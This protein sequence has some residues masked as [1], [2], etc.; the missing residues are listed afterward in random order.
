MA[1]LP[2]A[3]NALV[4][5]TQGVSFR[6]I[7]STNRLSPSAGSV[8]T[9][10]PSAST[11]IGVDYQTTTTNFT[12][13]AGNLYVIS[14]PAISFHGLLSSNFRYTSVANQSSGSV[15]TASIA[16][17]INNA[18]PYNPLP[19]TTG[20]TTQLLLICSLQQVPIGSG[21]IL[22]AM[23][24]N[25]YVTSP[26][27]VP[28]YGPWFPAGIKYTSFNVQVSHEYYAASTFSNYPVTIGI[29]AQLYSVHI[30]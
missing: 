15:P 10:P 29:A 24:F 9:N 4:E 1:K 16:T 21:G 12:V 6:P 8:I 11:L 30:Q 23:N 17:V 26:L 18:T 2:V 27:A 28:T 22:G 13:V 5:N 3:T 25:T 19:M 20:Q 7:I 14:Y